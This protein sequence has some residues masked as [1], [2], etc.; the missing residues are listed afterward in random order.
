MK[1]LV[2]GA[3]GFIG[4]HLCIKLLKLNHD[5]VGLDNLNNYYSPFLKESRLQ[6]IYQ[7]KKKF[8]FYKLDLIKKKK[9]F[10][11]FDEEK[12]DIVVNL[13]AQAGV[14]YSLKKP[15]KYI[16]SNIVGFM[17]ILENC[18]FFSIKHLILASSSSVYGL[19]EDTPFYE[20]SNTDQ[21]VSLYGATKKSNELMAHSYSHL[22]DL[23]CTCV[24]F[25]TVYGPWG[26]PDMALFK[27]TK[28]ILSEEPIELFNYGHM[29]RDFTYIDDV[30]E[31]LSKTLFKI[32]KHNKNYN[33]SK[34]K[35]LLNSSPFKVFNIGN[36]SPKS[37]IE[38]LEII[39][40]YLKKNAIKHFTEMEKGDVLIT[41]SNSDLIRNWVKVTP[42]TS[43]DQGIKKFIT[44]YKFF[45][46]VS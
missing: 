15:S 46:K 31:I 18:K 14:R 6:N 33:I 5:V 43:I 39:E 3:A 24:R 2:T 30:I 16:E 38:Y 36:N 42:E 34:P 44:W 40:K 37:I 4:M 21:P 1:V 26:R 7:L 11:L 20:E 8:R 27:F 10:N 32:P 35:K 25:F 41:H 13:A 22:F 29:V 9:L 23:P 12:F 17:N 45:Y 19:N 28:A